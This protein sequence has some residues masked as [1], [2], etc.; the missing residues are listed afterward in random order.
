MCRA[1]YAVDGL[2]YE[3]SIESI[4]EDEEGNKVEKTTDR[5]R[6]FLFQQLEIQNLDCLNFRGTGFLIF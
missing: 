6:G 1:V 3:C 5:K 4:A 2:E